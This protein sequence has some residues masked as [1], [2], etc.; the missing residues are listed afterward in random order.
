MHHS[1]ERKLDDLI[2]YSLNLL[3][4]KIVL[5]DRENNNFSEINFDN[6]H[7]YLFDYILKKNR[8]LLFN[9]R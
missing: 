5:T 1:V 6:N 7:R 4:K 9:R 3:G 8:C 2:K